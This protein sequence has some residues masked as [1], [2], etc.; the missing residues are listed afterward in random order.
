MKGDGGWERQ[1]WVEEKRMRE[2]KSGEKWEKVR[3]GGR[4]G[5]V[6]LQRSHKRKGEGEYTEAGNRIIGKENGGGRQGK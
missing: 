3:K 6:T 5:R 4:M 1:K 2:S